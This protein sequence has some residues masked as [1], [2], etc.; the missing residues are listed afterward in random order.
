MFLTTLAVRRPLIILIAAG[1]LLAFGLLA[2]TRLGVA[3]FPSIDTPVVTVVTPYPGAGPDAVDTLVTQKIE[4]AVNGVNDIDYIES[5]SVEGVST[6]AIYFTE[7][8]SKD[9][10][11]LVEQK[12]NAI[13]ND[14][15]TDTKT[16]VVTKIDGNGQ[17]VG[18][19]SGARDWASREV[20]EAFRKLIAEGGS[21]SVAGS[22]DLEPAMPL[23][24]ILRV[25]TA[26]I[27]VRS[28]QDSHSEAVG[29]LESG[30]QLVPLGKVSGAGE[31][32][33]MVKAKSGVMGWVRGS[34]VEEIRKVK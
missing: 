19:K 6:V 21:S 8:A 32:W 31:Y 23:P 12:V 7:K 30:E 13:R 14:L 17:A 20:V 9:S 34:E 16:P 15:P 1:A 5:D 4:D 26:G 18:M 22:M 25:K 11:H 28:Q 3:L 27:L 10:S 29:T 2:W 24:N 33:Y